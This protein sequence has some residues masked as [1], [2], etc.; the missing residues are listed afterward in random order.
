MRKRGRRTMK[1]KMSKGGGLHRIQ[2]V[3]YATAAFVEGS[4]S[5][6]IESVALLWLCAAGA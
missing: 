2:S 4:E 3:W 6:V 1:M 5:W